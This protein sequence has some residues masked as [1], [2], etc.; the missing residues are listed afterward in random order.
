MTTHYETLGIKP[1]ATPD[2]IR[3]ARRQ[4]ASSAHPDKGGTDGE[5]QAVNHAY[6]VLMD[7][8]ARK[9]YDET[10]EDPKP[11]GGPSP[12]QM[13]REV[14]ADLIGK[15]L[16]SDNQNLVK[17]AQR[18]VKGAESTLAAAEAEARRAVARL[19]KRRDKVRTKSGQPNVVHQVIDRKI[20]E[21]NATLERAAF[22]RRV[23]NELLRLAE[24][25]EDSTEEDVDPFA[26]M[27]RTS[28]FVS[29]T[30]AMR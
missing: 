8:E 22:T 30:G 7:P 18:A 4:R 27:F 5:M 2:Q 11:S 20:Q 12:E 9:R 26:S 1:D 24:D 14:L 17:M 6:A 3:K 29:G 19:D 25:Y 16:Q 10:G 13:A 21:H 28:A 23:N 15:W